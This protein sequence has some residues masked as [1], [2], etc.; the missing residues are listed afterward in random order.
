MEREGSSEG[1]I[2]G[3]GEDHP[4]SGRGLR[5]LSL[6]SAVQ[7]KCL[8]K[9]DRRAHCEAEPEG[10]QRAPAAGSTYC[11]GLQEWSHC[12]GFGGSSCH[13]SLLDGYQGHKLQNQAD[14]AL[15]CNLGEVAY[16]L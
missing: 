6:F 13:I 8:L 3:D 12:P 16:F 14:V 4:P 15:L 9:G 2:P 1:S 10:A 11:W 5:A 7:R